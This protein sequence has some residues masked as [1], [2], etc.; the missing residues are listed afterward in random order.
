MKTR[1]IEIPGFAS[2]VTLAGRPD[3][4][5]VAT[6]GG[7]NTGK[8]QFLTTAPEVVGVVPMDINSRFVVEKAMREGAAVVLSKTDHIRQKKPMSELKLM[9]DEKVKQY[10]RDHV[11]R[12]KTDI[13]NLMASKQVKTVAI[14]DFGQLCQDIG[15]AV[16]GREGIKI[17]TMGD[18]K[19][20]KDNA[21]NYAE[22]TDLLALMSSKNT[23]LTHK[24][25]DEY[26]QKG[27]AQADEIV[28]KTWD[29]PYKPLGHKVSLVLR[30]VLNS[31]YRPGA[32]GESKSWLYGMALKQVKARPELQGHEVVLK[33]VMCTWDMV[34]AVVYP[35]DEG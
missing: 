32:S 34:M 18:G 31:N 30:H 5:C 6:I 21:P 12:V 23:I 25:K 13:M 10:Y 19:L 26:G 29:N 14:D 3:N 4:N 9:S 24:E 2:E 17:K 15:F 20:F 8:T 35:E 22:I 7:P 1:A 11:E 33:D 16:H 27:T 28:G